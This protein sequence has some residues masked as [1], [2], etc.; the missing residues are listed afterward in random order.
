[1]VESHLARRNLTK[2]Q[3]ADLAGIHRSHLSDLL[4]GRKFAGPL[5]RQRLLKTLGT[6]FEE[7]F[8]IVVAA[9]G[10]RGLPHG[11]SGP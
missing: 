5:V 4:A 10:V 3:L 6:S 2:S 9:Y 8:E 7:L 1:V 11:G